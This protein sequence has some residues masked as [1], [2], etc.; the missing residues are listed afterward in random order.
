MSNEKTKK[1]LER[2]AKKLAAKKLRT[3]RKIEKQEAEAKEYEAKKD[4]R[5]KRANN[6]Y[7]GIGAANL[8][9]SVF[10]ALQQRSRGK[11]ALKDLKGKSPRIDSFSRNDRLNQ[12]LRDA[13][14]LSKEGMSAKDKAAL[15]SQIG[16]AHNDSLNRARVSSG[17]QAGLYSAQASKAA[18]DRLRSIERMQQQMIQA[19]DRN[20]SR[21]QNLINQDI[22]QDAAY[23]SGRLAQTQ[24]D[25]NAHNAQLRNAQALQQAGNINLNNKLS[26]MPNF[27]Y[28]VAQEAPF[29]QEGAFQ[30][31][32][33]R[34]PEQVI[35]DPT[36]ATVDTVNYGARPSTDMY[37]NSGVRAAY[38]NARQSVYGGSYNLPTQ[39]PS[40]QLNVNPAIRGL[41]NRTRAPQIQPTPQRFKIDPY[42]GI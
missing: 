37:V 2:E 31:P 12:E 36:Q 18:T 15:S 35:V 33:K 27:A 13:Y 3:A 38:D 14:Q 10:E 26:E 16:L 17:G 11:Q 7:Y 39:R 19:R 9:S 42:Y 30:N 28:Q 32:F 21:Y 23:R 22:G 25:I 40:T 20:T 41:Y 6:L 29:A 1:A 34:N 8:G 24:L 4:R 5:E